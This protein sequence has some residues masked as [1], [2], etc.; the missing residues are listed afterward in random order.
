MSMSLDQI[1][2]PNR[3]YKIEYKKLTPYYREIE[4]YIHNKFPN[5]HEWVQGK[6]QDIKKEILKYKV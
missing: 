4:K 1:A 5:K 6:I 2:D 3:G